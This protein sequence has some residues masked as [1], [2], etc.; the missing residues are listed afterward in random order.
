MDEEEV[1]CEICGNT[2]V[3]DELDHGVCETCWD[4]IEDEK[5]V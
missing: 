1:E 3:E 4:A 2:Y 5:D